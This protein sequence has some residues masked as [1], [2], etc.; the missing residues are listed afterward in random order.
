MKLQQLTLPGVFQPATTK[1]W[2][3]V[4][5]HS[6]IWLKPNQTFLNQPMRWLDSAKVSLIVNVCS[7][8]PLNSAVQSYDQV[9]FVTILS[10]RDEA[11]HQEGS[12]RGKMEDFMLRSS[13]HPDPRRFTMFVYSNL[14]FVLLRKPWSVRKAQSLILTQLIS[15]W[16]SWGSKRRHTRSLQLSQ[17]SLIM[18]HASSKLTEIKLHRKIPQPDEQQ[19]CFHLSPDS[20]SGNTKS[21]KTS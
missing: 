12:W 10:N 7:Y 9:I 8:L 11:E 19:S 1:S 21:F 3:L 20:S 16:R 5:Q 13:S 17:T 2:T 18:L 6:Q 4:W 14:C 15:W